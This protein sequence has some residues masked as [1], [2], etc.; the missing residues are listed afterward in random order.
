M[1]IVEYVYCGS[2]F[3]MEIP[4]SC[5]NLKSKV[6]PFKKH[7]FLSLKGTLGHFVSTDLLQENQFE[8]L[9]ILH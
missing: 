7:V 9:L 4:V 6:L 3:Y 5:I 1:Y 8:V 2:I